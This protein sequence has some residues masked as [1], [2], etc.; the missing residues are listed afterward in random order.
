MRPDGVITGRLS[1]HETGVLL[2]VVDTE[3]RYYDST[4]A[5]REP[6]TCG[7]LYSGDLIIDAR[8]D[9]RTTI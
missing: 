6:A 4:V 7:V 1:L 9:D 2:T 5:W 8:S 3:A